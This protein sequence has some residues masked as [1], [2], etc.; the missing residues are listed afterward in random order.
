MR[1]NCRWCSR[2]SPTA[3]T[4]LQPAPY[5]VLQ[6]WKRY[7]GGNLLIVLPDAFGTDGVPAR[8]ARLG[9]RL[10]RLPPRQRAADRG[11]RGDHRVVESSKGSDPRDKLLIFSDG[12]DVERSIETYRHFEGRVRMSFG[13][14]TNLT[15][16]FDG[17]RADGR[18]AGLEAISLVCKV[19]RGQR[20]AG[21]QALRQSATRRPASPAEIARYLRVFGDGRRPESAVEI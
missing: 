14:G 19:S 21:G 20:P 15:N 5:R 17:L 12:L 11:R 3:T 16:D 7:Y 1:T 18:I 8:R 13:W 9:R 4:Q 2:R 10:D 6:D